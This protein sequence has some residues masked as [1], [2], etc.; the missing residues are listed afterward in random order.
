M[1]SVAIVLP[2]REAFSAEAAGA[3]AMVARAH[4]RHGAW[5]AMVFGRAVDR[6]F[7]D[8][9]FQPV[10]LA[11]WPGREA[12][13]YAA[14][15]V[16]PLLAR[17]PD[18]IE[19]H[20]R[21]DIARALARRFPAVSLILHNDPRG[22]RGARS[23]AQR[24]RLRQVL[25][26]VLCVSFYLADRFGRGAGVGVL[27]NGLELAS[28]RLEGERDAEILFAGRVVADKGADL[29]V[30][31]CA[32][33][34]PLLPGWRARMIGAD[35]FGPDSPETPFL[36]RLRPAALAAGVTMDG[37]RP[38]DEV[39]EA[40]GRASIVVVPGRWPE[41]FGLVAL[42]AMAS[43]AALVV[44]PQGGLKEVVGDAGVAVT[45]DADSIAASIVA[46]A[47][48]P[49]RRAALGR[50]GMARAAAFDNRIIAAN[51]DAERAAILAT[52]SRPSA[53]PI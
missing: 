35:R 30:E 22:M 28:I 40:M 44:V 1:P 12:S 2:P 41:P 25:A 37:W 32:R 48:D 46:L 31:A 43:G 10:A 17:R 49:A 5:P 38:H 39:M 11:A 50:A 45:P 23:R 51:L 4:A 29:F 34:L 15:L 19:V 42:E 6:P 14:G 52:W 21:P 16:R 33:A 36:R 53:P 8:C 26:R 13:R 7:P 9:A 20:N 47:G 3:V 24:D 18:L 27:P